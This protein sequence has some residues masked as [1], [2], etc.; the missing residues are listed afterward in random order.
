MGIAVAV[1]LTL[2]LAVTLVFAVRFRSLLDPETLADRLEPRLTQAANRPVTIDGASL[3]L[4]PRPGVRVE[5]IRI[6]NRG[7]FSETALASADAVVLEPRLLPLLR[8]EV[9]IDR[10]LVRAPRLLLVVDENGTSNFG[11]FIPEP[12]EDAGGSSA[13]VGGM[14][15]DVRSL[16]IADGHVG[17]R[18]ASRSR[19]MQL[20]G[21]HLE[22]DLD[23]GDGGTVGSDGLAEVEMVSLRLPQLSGDGIEVPGA[24]ISWNGRVALEPGT[25]EIDRAEL[26]AGP[27]QARLTGRIDSLGQPVR[28]VEVQV[29]AEGLSIEELIGPSDSGHQLHGALEVDLRLDGRAGPGVSPEAS[30]LITVRGGEVRTAAEVALVTGLEAD[31]EIRNGRGELRADGGLLDGDLALTGEVSID[32]LFPYDL[33]LLADTDLAELLAALPE[34]PASSSGRISGRLTVDAA[35]SGSS[36][37]QGAPFVD[38]IVTLT[39]VE[40]SLDALDRPVTA[41]RIPIRIAGDSA[42]WSEVDLF[43]GG[44]RGATS[45]VA[46]RLFGGSE[47]RDDRPVLDADL[48]FDL[49]ALD[50]LIP[51]GDAEGLGWGRLVSARLGGRPIGAMSAEQLAVERG[52]RRPE[53][54]PVAGVVRATIDELLYDGHRVT[55]LEGSVRIGRERIDI[56]EMTFGAYGGRGTA[57]ASLELG[58]GHVEPFGLQLDLQDVRAE[59]WLARQT[60]LG[61]FV[62]GTMGIELELAGGLDSLLL[63]ESESLAGSGALRIVD[64]TIEPNPLTRAIASAIGAADPTG[65]RLQSWV[66]RFRIDDGAVHMADGRLEFPAGDLD[67]AGAVSFDGRLDLSLGLKPDPATVRD[68]ADRNLSALPPGVREALTSG[69]VP[70]LGLLVRGSIGDPQVTVDPASVRRAQDA[71]VEAGRSEIERR[72]LDLLKRLTG[73]PEDSAAAGTPDDESDPR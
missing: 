60:P 54:P 52:Q 23:F 63:P 32:S 30:G 26:V 44:N 59:E 47:S 29:R 34:A 8:R 5:G 66:S 11:D 61:E 15:L 35:I 72:G 55:D 33:R 20:D 12:A 3:R 1:L 64:G 13:G 37:S 73:E 69:G 14:S 65:G 17:F 38:G 10:I 39:D 19:G 9:V 51:P 27:L 16:E 40:A 71:I 48:H 70:E 41:T 67:L 56:P 7:I 18:D 25:L 31:M 68:L 49:L 45:G 28:H 22:T 50:E 2:L 42:S 4:W 58:S 53:E 24:S 21:V 46:T 36:G 62:T 57:S 43:L 6:A